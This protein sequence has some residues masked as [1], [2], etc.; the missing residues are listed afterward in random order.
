MSVLT[1][2]HLEQQQQQQQNQTNVLTF[3]E[4]NIS[5]FHFK[6]TLLLLGFSTAVQKAYN[7]TKPHMKQV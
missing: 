3:L 2:I 5:V 6:T 1:Q 7:E 4:Q